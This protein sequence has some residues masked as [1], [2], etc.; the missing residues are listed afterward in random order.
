MIKGSIHQKH[1]ILVNIYAA[2]IEATK[3]LEQILTDTRRELDSNTT[4]E[5]FNTT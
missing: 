2:N 4:V 1:L 5:E 3:Y